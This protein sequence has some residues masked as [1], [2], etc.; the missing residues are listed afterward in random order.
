MGKKRAFSLLLATAAVLGC[1]QNPPQGAPE[2]VGPTW[3]LVRFQG[4]DGK[5]DMPV[6]RSQYSLVFNANGSVFARIDCNRGSGTWKSAGPGGLEIGPMAMTRA[7][8]PPRS[9]YNQV[10]TQLPNVRSYVIRNGHLFLSLMAD[11]GIYE[12]EPAR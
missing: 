6:D 2:L 10:E 8:C 7:M 4:G 1:A 3:Q 9:L 11:G 12:F 5:V